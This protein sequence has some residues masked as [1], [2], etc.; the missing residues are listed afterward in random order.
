MVG[1]ENAVAAIKQ[2]AIGYLLKERLGR[3]GNAVERALEEKRGQRAGQT[4][5]ANAPV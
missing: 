1:E 4:G 2:G 5:R 3:L